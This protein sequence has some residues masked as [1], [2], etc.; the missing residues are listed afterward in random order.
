MIEIDGV[1]VTKGERAILRGIN[2]TISQQRTAI[3]GANGSG[4]STLARLLNGI[5]LPTAGRVLVDG[6]DTRTDDREVRRRV[7]FVFQDPDAQL[8]YPTPL[9]DVAL[10]LGMLQVPDV[11]GVNDVETAV[12]MDDAAALLAG[13][14]T[15]GQE[16]A[17][18]KDFVGLVGG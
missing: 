1:S 7:G 14:E 5:D 17:F 13:E 12:A 6:L 4:K 8:V 11:A 2:L 16:L 15:E 3:I 10:G 18:G 9:E